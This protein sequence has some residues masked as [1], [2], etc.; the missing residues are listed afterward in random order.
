MAGGIRTLDRTNS[1]GRVTK[2]PG[3]DATRLLQ[4]RKPCPGSTF[5][6]G[7]CPS[8][9]RYAPAAKMPSLSSGGTYICYLDESGVPEQGAGT[10]HFVL[11]GLAIPAAAWRG[12]DDE[13]TRIKQPYG[14]TDGEIHA[15]W[16]FRRYVE[17]EHIPDFDRLTW[18]ER[19]AA[20]NLARAA[21]VAKH[22]TS[23]AASKKE[24]KKNHAKTSAY[25]HLTRAERLS[26]LERVAATV[27][28]WPECR[29]FAEV[30]DKRCISSRPGQTVF[31]E[32]FSQVV[33]RFEQFLARTGNVGLLVQDNNETV[34]RKL[35]EVMR[36]FHRSGT[37]W[38]AIRHIVETPLFVESA[39]TGMVQV[40]DL[41]AFVLRRFFEGGGLELFEP[42][43]SRVDRR[44]GL[45]V[46]MRHYTSATPCG[47]RVCVDHGRRTG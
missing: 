33:S 38:T 30:V 18:G 12:C 27:G 15:A 35:T 28:G 26:I 8:V 46:G 17:Q 25:V 4:G 19:R 9:G 43:Y 44:G 22:P 42:F 29:I 36:R 31:E 21:S 6:I 41:C 16:M 5:F 10:A 11:V 1:G 3:R 13:I 23:G 37:T 20:V 45:Q 24:L 40:A 2:L 7:R 14:L 32:A 34:A 39:L 47:C